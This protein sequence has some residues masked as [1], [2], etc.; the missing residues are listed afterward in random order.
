MSAI[1]L[2]YTIDRRHL[3]DLETG[4]NVIAEHA[5]RV[6]DDYDWSG[7]CMF[8]TLMYLEE[9]GITFGTVGEYTLL[10]PEDRPAVDPARHNIDDLAACLMEELD[11]GVDDEETAGWTSQAGLE[12]LQLLH[13]H[14]ERLN[15][16][17][18]LL[19]R[20]C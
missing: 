5:L 17:R 12:S 6:G 18:V 19:L 7:Y 11:D 3:P 8:F 9:Q 10:T 15:G 2:L 13:D 4:D 14:I 1:L 20:I 16:D